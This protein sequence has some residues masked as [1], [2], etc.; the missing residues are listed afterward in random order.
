[1]GHLVGLS[2]HLYISTREPSNGH[3]CAH[4]RPCARDPRVCIPRRAAIASGAHH[5][6]AIGVVI[7]PPLDPCAGY[8][9]HNRIGAS[10]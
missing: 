3:C 5:I 8:K 2:R 6:A 4:V 7:G 10:G 1:M 9:L